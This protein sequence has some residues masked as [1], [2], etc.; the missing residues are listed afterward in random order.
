MSCDVIAV[1]GASGHTGRFVV[2]EIERRGMGA[3]RV[4]R[5][6]ERLHRSRGAMSDSPMRIADISDAKSLAAALEGASL[7]IN[8]AGPFLDTAL[9]ILDAALRAR[10]PYL[11]VTAEQ[12][13]VQSI[14]GSRY[15][16]AKS[17]EV[18]VL[19]AA[20]FYGGL[21]DLLSSALARGL[22]SIDSID[23]AVGLD[24]WH[25]TLGTRLTGQ[26]NR[27]PRLVQND[28]GLVTIASPAP[29]TVWQFSRPIG[30]RKVLAVPLSE[31]ITITSHLRAR[32]VTSWMNVEPLQDLENSA[33]PP[34]NA[35]GVK[36]SFGPK[37][38]HGSSSQGRRR[39]TF[40]I[41][42][43]TRYLPYECNDSC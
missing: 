16:A 2:A 35:G 21:A 3:I 23:V 24:S 22:R 8:C 20:A 6:I 26:R 33:T 17:A 11:D 43:R 18:A 34:P 38:R 41:G 19:P 12:A 28:G 4:G 13:V 25:P 14:F 32:R 10:I 40:D 42:V 27:A 39:N 36:R 30:T 9:P 37:F 31:I 15:V 5:N 7:V 1:V 29:A